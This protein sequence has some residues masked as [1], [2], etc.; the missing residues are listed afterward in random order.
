MAQTTFGRDGELVWTIDELGRVASPGCD[1]ADT[2]A[3]IVHLVQRRFTADA[4]SLYLLESE[5]ATLVLTAS[6]GLNPEN[7]G[8][9]GV[10]V[11]DGPIGAAAE[12]RTANVHPSFVAVP[13]IHRSLLQGVIVMQ[14]RSPRV[15]NEQDAQQLVAGVRQ[16]APFICQARAEV[17]RLLECRL[18]ER[19][20]A[21]LLETLAGGITHELNNKL[22]PITSYAELML[23]EA[24]DGASDD[25]REG[26]ETIRESAFEA[27]HILEQLVLIANTHPVEH[28]ACDLTAAV[29]EAVAALQPE[30]DTAGVRLAAD[31]HPAPLQIAGHEPHL[32]QVCVNLMR[33][34]MEAM[35]SAANRELTLHLEKTEGGAILTVSDRGTGIAPD[36][37]PRI[38]DPYFTTKESRSEGVGLSFCQAV[39]KQHGGDIRVVSRMGQGTAFHVTLPVRPGVRVAVEESPAAS[40]PFARFE[41][42]RVLVID[43]DERMLE[44]VAV[45]LESKL[46][47]RVDRARNGLDARSALEHGVFDLVLSDVHMPLM[48]GVELLEWITANQPNVLRRTMFMTGDAM[49]K[50]PSGDIQRSGRPLLRKPFSLD[51][52]VS[53]ASRMISDPPAAGNPN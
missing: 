9:A 52:L 5:R 45:V 26:C 47:C 50:G 18:V 24:G 39:V 12:S 49:T 38:F 20:K 37:L 22:M 41:S 3:N 48:D 29:R 19:A 31:I 7:V 1:P 27:A 30:L 28:A 36:M 43:D 23:E 21:D 35:G 40:V 8:R 33:N 2:L 16:L 6:V 13:V 25:L 15:F 11:G 53:A 34:A 17:R 10:R 4:C 32:R 51:A 14:A 42:R 46:G 44:L